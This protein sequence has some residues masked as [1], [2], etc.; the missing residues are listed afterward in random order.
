MEARMHKLRRRIVFFILAFTL[1][2]I[3][4]IAGEKEKQD[5]LQIIKNRNR[6]FANFSRQISQSNLR[7][8]QTIQSSVHSESF[9]FVLIGDSAGSHGNQLFH[10]LIGQIRRL[11]PSPDF[12]VHLG[13]FAQWG[14]EEEYTEFI[15]ILSESNI[16]FLQVAGNHDIRGN[17]NL[18]FSRIFGSRDYYFDLVHTRFVFLGNA[19]KKAKAGF[20]ESQLNWLEMVLKQNPGTNASI[21]A[22]IP[23]T[24][25]FNQYTTNLLFRVR[26]KLSNQDRFIRLLETHRVDLACFGHHHY[27]ATFTHHNVRYLI[28]GGGGQPKEFFFVRG[29]WQGPDYSSDHHFC[30]LDMNG[31]GSYSGSVVPLNRSEQHRHPS[32]IPDSYCFSTPIPTYPKTMVLD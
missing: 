7:S 2:L 27:F 14:K 22:H 11:T 21:F 17:G 16:P 15:Q 10:E 6:Q 4:E 24:Y 28:S 29:G 13:D 8:I 26:R 12:L 20:S 25:P 30:I 32:I 1:V 9:R 3:S 31:N 23:P 5:V 18:L 19:N